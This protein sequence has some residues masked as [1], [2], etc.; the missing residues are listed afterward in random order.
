MQQGNGNKIR[1]L[2]K[3]LDQWKF[4]DEKFIPVKLKSLSN[5]LIHIIS[6][7][8]IILDTL[9][10]IYLTEGLKE[11]LTSEE[12]LE[13]VSKSNTLISP[14]NFKKKLDC[15]TNLKLISTGFGTKV[16]R[17][18]ELKNAFSHPHIEKYF[19]KI[20]KLQ[21][22]KVELEKEMENLNSIT[23]DIDALKQGQINF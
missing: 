2:Q 15:A 19:L 23:E 8:D 22:N 11:K 13:I 18:I 9:I 10:G 4:A 6:W 17:A 21:S 14:M 5:N 1:T 16:N 20:Q 3:K 7:L 12:R